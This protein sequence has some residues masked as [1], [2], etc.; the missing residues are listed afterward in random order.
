[1]FRTLD[2]DVRRAP[3]TLAG[4]ESFAQRTRYR[5]HSNFYLLTSGPIRRI[6]MLSAL[7]VRSDEPYATDTVSQKKIVGNA[8][9]SFATTTV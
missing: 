4:D 3:H 6:T 9:V 2:S 7:T 1:M 5:I 8:R